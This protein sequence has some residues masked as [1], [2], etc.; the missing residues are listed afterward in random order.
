ML[1]P[2]AHGPEPFPP[3]QCGQSFAH[4]LRANVH[5]LTATEI[6]YKGNCAQD[7]ASMLAKMLMQKKKHF[8][9]KFAKL[10]L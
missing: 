10:Y 5:V 3:A 7:L 1:Y 8:V 6:V 2:L 9:F 4:Q